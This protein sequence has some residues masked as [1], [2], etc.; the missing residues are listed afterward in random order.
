MGVELT[1][2]LIGRFKHIARSLPASKRPAFQ[3]SV[4]LEFCDGSPRLAESTFGWS[5]RGRPRGR[6]NKKALD[7]DMKPLAQPIP[8]G[9]LEI[10]S[11]P[12]FLTFGT[13][14][15]TSDFIV[16]CLLEEH[17]NGTLLNTIDTALA[18]AST[19][20]DRQSR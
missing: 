4:A 19:L 6:K 7:H 20:R 15:E 16:D 1:P 9:I 2:S 10:E 3:A 14:R 11:A 17:W 5:R 13:S 18:W 8:F 12:W